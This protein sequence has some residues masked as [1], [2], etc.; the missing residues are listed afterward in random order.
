MSQGD[1][2]LEDLGVKSIKKIE[3]NESSGKKRKIKRKAS[4]ESRNGRASRSRSESHSSPKVASVSGYDKSVHEK[5]SSKAKLNRQDTKKSI[6]T[7][8]FDWYSKHPKPEN[9]LAP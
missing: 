1:E 2:F 5:S 9:D 3:E 8:F 7:V 4:V 6:V